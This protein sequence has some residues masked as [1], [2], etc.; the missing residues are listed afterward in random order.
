[1]PSNNLLKQLRRSNKTFF[2]SL[3]VCRKCC[4]FADIQALTKSP[5]DWAKRKMSQHFEI[6]GYAARWLGDQL[7]SFQKFYFWIMVLSLL[8][9]P[10]LAFVA[11]FFFDAPSRSFFDDICRSGMAFT[12]WL[13]PLYL[14]PL[15]R[16]WFRF[17]KR[18]GATW[19]YYFCP[20][21]VANQIIGSYFSIV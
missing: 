20:F 5:N 12:I 19:L 13:Y 3:A 11:L 4:T 9:W 10:I 8:L 17:S 7:T 15:I 18:I 2:R 1:M 21:Y 14:L 16:L 6:K